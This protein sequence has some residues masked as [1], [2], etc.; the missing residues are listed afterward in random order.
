MDEEQYQVKEKS[1]VGTVLA[2]LVVVALV[3]RMTGDPTSWGVPD[4]SPPAEST[5]VNISE[6]SSGDRLVISEHSQQDREARASVEATEAV[7]GLTRGDGSRGLL[8]SSASVAA[9]EPQQTSPDIEAAPAATSIIA[10][11]VF[12]GQSWS[13]V[14][15]EQETETIHTLAAGL[16]QDP[17][18]SLSF[19]GRLVAYTIG[20][21]SESVI[22]VADTFTGS[23]VFSYSLPPATQVTRLAFDPEADGLLVSVDDTHGSHAYRIDLGSGEMIQ[24]LPP[25]SWDLTASSR[26]DT[27]YVVPVGD[28]QLIV[29]ADALGNADR[30]VGEGFQCQAAP[31]FSPDG[32][33]LA[34]VFNACGDG[35]PGI[36]VW[37]GGEP[38]PTLDSTSSDLVI[39]WS[40]VAGDLY[41]ASCEGVACGLRA[42]FSDSDR[43]PID[44]PVTGERIGTVSWAVRATE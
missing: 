34:F 8:V 40:P 18:P 3:L 26:G 1:R 4:E 19:D 43:Q 14:V 20:D 38:G 7:A 6:T 32:G 35:L 31:I 25:Q 37:S 2:L 42:A 41:L 29:Q 9:T 27:A 16:S 30:F 23:N 33:S 24:F 21:G 36:A 11:S 10:L 13:A 5:G 17:V 15:L 39:V 28:D 12:D 22:Y 44:L